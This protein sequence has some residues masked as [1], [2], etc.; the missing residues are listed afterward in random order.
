LTEYKNVSLFWKLARSNVNH[1][2]SQSTTVVNVDDS[3]AVYIVK[4][5]TPPHSCTVKMMINSILSC[6]PA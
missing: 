2:D 6:G 4:A 3:T 5:M 1:D